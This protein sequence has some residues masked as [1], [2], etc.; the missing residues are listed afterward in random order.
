MDMNIVL[1]VITVMVGAGGGGLGWLLKARQE[2]RADV[3]GLRAENRK[4]KE[5]LDEEREKRQAAETRIGNLEG[6]VARLMFLADSIHAI[7]VRDCRTPTICPLLPLF[8]SPAM[9]HLPLF[10]AALANR[11]AKGG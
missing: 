5:E 4:L 10:A 9:A 11:Q 6:K 8:D 1:A 7:I 2:N 3:E